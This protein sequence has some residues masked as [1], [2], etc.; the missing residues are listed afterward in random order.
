MNKY[1]LDVNDQQDNQRDLIQQFCETQYDTQSLHNY[2]KKDFDRKFDNLIKENLMDSYFSKKIF[3]NILLYQNQNPFDIVKN[4]FIVSLQQFCFWYPNGLQM[5]FEYRGEL[6]SGSINDLA[7]VFSD[8]EIYTELKKLILQAPTLR[9]ERLEILEKSMDFLETFYYTSI[10]N[11]IYQLYS[12]ELFDNDFFKKKREYFIMSIIRH[13]KINKF[14]YNFITYNEAENVPIECVLRNTMLL[15][16]LKRHF[17]SDFTNEDL[18]SF[19]NNYKKYKNYFDIEL[20]SN[21]CVDYQI[22]RM[23]EGMYSMYSDLESVKNFSD[24]KKINHKIKSANLFIQDSPDEV[25]YR[26]LAYYML[27][28]LEE[29]NKDKLNLNQEELDSFMF[30]RRHQTSVKET[31]FHLCLTTNY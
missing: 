30:D 13:I 14:F 10:E 6:N 21:P 16:N 3:N 5:D 1:I 24:I 28:S 31:K 18:I 9:K 11:L 25:T 20:K 29:I 23:L 26:S 12:C 17:K 8:S 19:C 15:N 27:L 7:F 2:V 4:L 22:P